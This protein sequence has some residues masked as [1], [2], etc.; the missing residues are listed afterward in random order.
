MFRALKRTSAHMCL[1]GSEPY[2]PGSRSAARNDKEARCFLCMTASNDGDVSDDELAVAPLAELGWHVE[3]RSWRDETVNGT[4]LTRGHSH[5]LGLSARPRGIR[6]RRKRSKIRPPGSR[7]LDIVR[8]NLSKT[9]LRERTSGVCP[10][11][12]TFGGTLFSDNVAA[13]LDRFGTAN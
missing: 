10:I 5:H 1:S 6:H 4:I 7:P 11:V 8:W 12:P 9:Y 3:T 13:W 2:K